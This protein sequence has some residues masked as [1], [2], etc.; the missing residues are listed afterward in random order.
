MRQ[1]I[2][3]DRL[4]IKQFCQNSG[5]PLVIFDQNALLIGYNEHADLLLQLQNKGNK[6]AIENIAGF[7]LSNVSGP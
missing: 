4:I 3:Q 5:I 7:M 2:N 1:E 6:A